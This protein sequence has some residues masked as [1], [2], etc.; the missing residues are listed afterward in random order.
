MSDLSRFRAEQL[1]DP[2]FLE[3]YLDMKPSADIAKA[4]IGIRMERNLLQRDLADLTGVHQADISRLERGEGSPSLKTLKKI[5][6]GLG[7][8]VKIELVPIETVL[9]ELKE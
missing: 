4:I 2:E 6:S 9:E 1:N 8:A 5:A 7:M 3:Y